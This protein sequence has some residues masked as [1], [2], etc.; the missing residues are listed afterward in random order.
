M[1]AHIKGEGEVYFCRREAASTTAVTWVV[2]FPPKEDPVTRKLVLGARV[3]ELWSDARRK[4]LDSESRE[5][6]WE[7]AT[8]CLPPFSRS[9]PRLVPSTS[10]SSLCP[11]DSF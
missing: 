4:A 3:S 8:S 10:Y 9:A 6:M 7:E 11:R 1:G 2:P 5:G